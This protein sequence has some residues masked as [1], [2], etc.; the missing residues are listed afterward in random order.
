MASASAVECTATDVMPISRQARITRSAISPRFAIR[1]FSNIVASLHDHQGG[2]VFDGAAVLDQNALDDPALG[3]G[4][5][6]IVFIA[7]I[8]QHGLARGHRRTDG[9]KGLRARF[10]DRYTVPT[11]GEVT[12]P[13][14]ARVL[15]RGGR[16]RA[17]GAAA[18]A[19]A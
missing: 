16:C 19:G 13:D 3:A 6:F 1:I 12:A 18:T 15:H 8:D 5:W 11:M 10:G 7:S 9:R 14:A 4:M 2:S 17:A